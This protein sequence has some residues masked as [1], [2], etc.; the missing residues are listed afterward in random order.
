MIKHTDKEY[1]ETKRI[2]QNRA[3]MN[4]RFTALASW[5]QKEYDAAP[6]NIHYDTIADNR[7]RLSI[8]FEYR[9]DELK[10]RDGYLGNFHSEKQKAV[11]DTFNALVNRDRDY[12]SKNLH[13]IF[14]SFEP[15]AKDEANSSVPENEIKKLEKGLEAYHVWTIYRQFSSTTFFLYTDAQVEEAHEKGLVAVFTDAYF[16]ILKEYDEFDYFK[17]ESFSIRLDSK[18]NFDKNYRSNWFYYSR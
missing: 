18:E 11:S 14:T 5:I 8:I 16:N 13:V 7:P 17:R 6:L 9:D 12:N 15:R 3:A 10:F 2:K 4:P 1:I